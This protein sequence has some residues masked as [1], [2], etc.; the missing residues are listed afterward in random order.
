[1][2]PLRLDNLFLSLFHCLPPPLQ[3][4]VPPPGTSS[5]ITHPPEMGSTSSRDNCFFLSQPSDICYFPNYLWIR[6]RIEKFTVDRNRHPMFYWVLEFL[7][8]TFSF[9]RAVTLSAYLTSLS[10]RQSFILELCC[11]LASLTCSLAFFSLTAI[12]AMAFSLTSTSLG[13]DGFNRLREVDSYIMLPS[14]LM[15][16]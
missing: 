8:K 4:L 6:N 5:V 1:M 2:L 3:Q 9:L 10:K 16:G 7:Y 12:I 13:V 15:N 14:F 11:F